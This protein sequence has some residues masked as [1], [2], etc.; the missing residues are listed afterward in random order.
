M[1]ALQQLIDTCETRLTR[2]R[3][4]VVASLRTEPLGSGPVMTT[5]GTCVQTACVLWT[6]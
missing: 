6:E 4:N 2:L 3:T 5:R 1:D